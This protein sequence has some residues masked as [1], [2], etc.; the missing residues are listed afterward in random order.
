MSQ[1]S[2]N[3][4]LNPRVVAALLVVALLI[5]VAYKIPESRAQSSSISGKFGCITNTNSTGFLQ[6]GNIGD[7][8][9]NTLGI[10][11][12]DLKTGVGISSVTSNFNTNNASLRNFNESSS[13]TLVS[14]PFAGSY[15]LTF[16]AGGIYTVIPVNSGN[17]LLVNF[18]RTG[19][20]ILPETGVCQRI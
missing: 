5:G 1:V 20:G 19:P 18:A 14:G 2:L 7:A 16:S 12:F 8:F 10:F 11:D 9:T 3:I 4:N 13:F 6:A 15:T 17:T